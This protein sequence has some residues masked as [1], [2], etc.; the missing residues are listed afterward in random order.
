MDST[1][2]VVA[3]EWTEPFVVGRIELNTKKLKR[4][5]NVFACE[6]LPKF[7]VSAQTAIQYSPVYT[8]IQVL[9]FVNF[10]LVFLRFSKIIFGV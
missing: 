4:F 2:T 7:W 3:C 10:L 6:M 9:E 1:D 8:A 5:F